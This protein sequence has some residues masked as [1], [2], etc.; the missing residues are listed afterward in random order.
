MCIC[1]KCGEKF[2]NANDLRNHTEAKHKDTITGNKINRQFN[3]L[4]CPFQG[5][6]SLELKKHVMR[7]QHI[8]CE[9]KE[10]C[11]SCGKEFKSYFY[12]MTHRKE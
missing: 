3:C 5:E 11:Y 1:E 4:D 9:Y 10:N 2:E 6:S 8:P 12:L 7:T